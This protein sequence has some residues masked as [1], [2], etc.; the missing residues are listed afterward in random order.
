M[1]SYR[2]CQHTAKLGCALELSEIAILSLDVLVK[3]LMEPYPSIICFENA[4]VTKISYF[5]YVVC[6]LGY[7]L[8]M[9]CDVIILIYIVSF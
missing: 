4:N 2:K 1:P 6:L 5:Q 7:L 8:Y 3:S 9:F